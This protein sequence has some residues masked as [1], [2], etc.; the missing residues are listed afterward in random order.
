MERV[1]YLGNKAQK[2]DNV[3]WTGVVWFGNGD[4]Q[5]VPDG[6]WEKLSK[7]PDVWRLVPRET[8]SS[9]GQAV[10]KTDTA[11]GRSVDLTAL[12][13]EGLRAYAEEK[14]IK[15]DARLKDP[16]KILAAIQEAEA[17]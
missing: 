10:A 2:M 13:A 1:E 7:H 9:V 3:A 5:E 8:D 11:P 16:A 6:T 4:I 12:D 15:L 17:A 14:G